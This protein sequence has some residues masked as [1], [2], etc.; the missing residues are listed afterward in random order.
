MKLTESSKRMEQLL[1]RQVHRPFFKRYLGRGEI[2]QGISICDPELSYA[3][4]LFSA[5]IQIRTLK[6]LQAAEARGQ[7]DEEKKWR[8]S[9][10]HQRRRQIQH[11]DTTC[12]PPSIP[13]FGNYTTTTSVRRTLYHTY[14]TL[15]RPSQTKTLRHH[16]RGNAI[17]HAM[18]RREAELLGHALDLHDLRQL[19]C[20]AL[21]TSNDADIACSA[22]S[23]G[24]VARGV[25]DAPE[26]LDGPEA[27]S[28][29]ASDKSTDSESEAVLADLKD[30]AWV[31]V[32][33]LDGRLERMVVGEEEEKGDIDALRRLSGKEPSLPSW[34]ITRY[35]VDLEERAGMR[36]FSDVYRGAWRGKTVAI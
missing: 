16:H 7:A 10:H 13:C 26:G 2:L 35:E 14:H 18:H 28:A 25:E 3:L 6:Q 33:V 9:F 5:S 20:I 36:F 24:R 15:Q 12:P 1:H 34:P 21:A 27:A 22:S 8:H 4:S 32:K 30:F 31:E 19:M 29:N 11:L 17:R 23:E